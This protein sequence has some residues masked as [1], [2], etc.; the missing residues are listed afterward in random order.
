MSIHLSGFVR[1]YHNNFHVKGKTHDKLLDLRVLTF[2]SEHVSCCLPLFP[3]CKTDLKPT[4]GRCW[5]RATCST[6]SSW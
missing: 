4:F 1:V 6:P 5:A 2:L 3:P